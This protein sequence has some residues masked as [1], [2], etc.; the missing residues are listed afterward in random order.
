MASLKSP[1]GSSSPD[2]HG[3]GGAQSND[4]NSWTAPL[5]GSGG[6]GGSAKKR[7]L[8]QAISE[9]TETESPTAGGLCG[10]IGSGGS[11]TPLGNSGDGFDH[12]T[13]LK[14]RRLAR[15]SMSSETSFTPPSTPTPS[16]AI[17]GGPGETCGLS[18]ESSVNVSAVVE[19][20]PSV[21][22]LSGENSQDTPPDCNDPPSSSVEVDTSY[23]NATPA[24]PSPAQPLSE[25]RGHS[26]EDV[27]L[28]DTLQPSWT[29]S[30]ESIPSD[31]ELSLGPGEPTAAS[32]NS[33]FQ[34]F[35]DD[36]FNPSVSRPTWEFRAPDAQFMRQ[37]SRNASEVMSTD[38]AVDAP[39]TETSVEGQTIES[40]APK[41]IKRKVF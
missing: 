16:N 14:K 27:P 31:A 10:P 38:S 24:A 4:E 33:Q 11:G 40:P 2:P 26:C 3:D 1:A 13:P 9:E 19:E 20:V 15:A 35:G 28:S 17:P 18:S 39:L 37:I 30:E 29:R 5:P 25:E 21:E 23:L 41:P 36:V 32:V 7:W 22:S 12:V 6:P 34:S 8:R